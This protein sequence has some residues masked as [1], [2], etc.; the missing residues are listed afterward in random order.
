MF[1]AEKVKIYVA[2]HKESPVPKHPLLFPIQ[3]G[4]ALTQERFP[5]MIADDTGENIS[6]KNRSYCEL[7]AQY[8][9]W[10]N[11]TADWQGLFH[12]RRYLDFRSLY[13]KNDRIKPYWIANCP[14]EK[15]LQ[16]A[17]YDSVLLDRLKDYDAVVPL[18]EEMYIPGKEQYVTAPHH[19]E[20]DLRLTMEI[21]QKSSPQDFRAAEQYLNNTRIYIGNL[22]LL[23]R[24][25]FTRYS[26]WLFDL[27]AQYDA[28]KNISGY[29]QQA[30]RVDGY[31]AERLLGVFLTRLQNEGVS[32]A[33]VPRIHFAGLDG[34]KSYWKKKTELFLLPSGS[35]RRGTVR[36]L[37]RRYGHD[38]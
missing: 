8:W 21:L 20:R 29:S 36:R 19:Y 4:S 1:L 14:T 13:S 30:L 25:L 12:Y 16:Q 2:C 31:L 5:G 24:K 11:D 38:S 17:G 6:E 7:T 22:F 33:Y 32:I 34:P 15:I 9:A 18:P 27:L 35:I 23:R 28:Q 3:V 37:F 26:E 10:K